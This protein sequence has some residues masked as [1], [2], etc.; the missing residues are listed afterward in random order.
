[1]RLA[2]GPCRK[3]LWF[4]ETNLRGELSLA[5]IAAFGGVPRFHLLR[6]FG[7]ATGYSVMS[8]VRCRRLTEAAKRLAAGAGDILAV[9]L[10]AWLCVPRGFTRAFRD[11]FGITPEAARAQ[12]DLANHRT[13]GGYR[14]GRQI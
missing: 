6:A 10:D 11:Q 8:Y 14:D 12:G 2:H 7:A 3:S 13:R 9:A 5:E 4:I 1:M